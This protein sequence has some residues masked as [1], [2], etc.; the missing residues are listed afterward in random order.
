MLSPLFSDKEH[1]SN[2]EDC[3]DFEDSGSNFEESNFENEVEE[4]DQ[5]PVQSAVQRPVRLRGPWLALPDLELYQ[6]RDMGVL[7]FQNQHTVR[8]ADS[9]TNNEMCLS[10]NNT[11]P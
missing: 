3:Q 4:E 2:V 11:Q 9:S 10:S 8:V 1:F 7:N 6:Q 5:M